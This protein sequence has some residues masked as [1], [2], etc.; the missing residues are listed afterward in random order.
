[1]GNFGA[2]A[3]P[4][5]LIDVLVFAKNHVYKRFFYFIPFTFIKNNKR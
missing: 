1:M 5:Y 3:R 4:N 2:A